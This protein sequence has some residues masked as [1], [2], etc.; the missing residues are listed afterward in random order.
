M[1][2]TISKEELSRALHVTQNVVEKKTTM[3]ILANVLLSATDG[4]HR[5][6]HLTESVQAT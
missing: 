4:D 2:I 3:P 6:R 5:R 1:E